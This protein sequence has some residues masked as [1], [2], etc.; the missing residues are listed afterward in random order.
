M[1]ETLTMLSRLGSMFE[2]TASVRDE[3]DLQEVLQDV[4]RAIGEV[5]GYRAVV[6]NVYRPAF[7]DMLTA[8]AVG[9]IE[10]R[11][12]LLGTSS[13]NDTWTPLFADRFE[14]RGAYFI[15]D[16]E[17]DWDSLGVSTYV[18]DLPPSDDPDAWLPGDAL[19]VPLRDAGGAI[20]GVISVD[21]PESGLRP[22]E[23]QLDALVTISRHAALALQ[24]A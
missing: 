17:F 10:S 12:Q 4:A 22:S 6:V 24:I 16:G 14:H 7:D 1:S 21:E 3:A 20:L 8:A 23:P 15:L 5:L 11:E 19:F 9:S 18:P 2:R 13:P